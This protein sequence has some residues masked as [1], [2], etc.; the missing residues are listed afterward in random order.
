MLTTLI[1]SLR[2]A[3]T[4]FPLKSLLISLAIGVLLGVFGPFKS[5][6]RSS[7]PTLKEGFMIV[8]PT[9]SLFEPLN[10]LKLRGQ[11]V[12]LIH[13]EAE[14]NFC[15]INHE[16]LHFSANEKIAI[17]SG[18]LPSIESLVLSIQESDLKRPD[19]TS[20]GDK[21]TPRCVKQTKIVYG[22]EL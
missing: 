2:H 5:S 8:F 17:L 6:S 18:N 4:R 14:S 11:K 16:S 20:I 9:A 3:V 15:K 22:E 21:T 10:D 13:R 7:I 19:I 1:H 12:H